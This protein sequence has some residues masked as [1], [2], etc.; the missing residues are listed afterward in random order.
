[1]DCDVDQKAGNEPAGSAAGLADAHEC[2]RPRL[3]AQHAGNSIAQGTSTQLHL[4]DNEAAQAVLPELQVR[5]ALWHY[6][7][8]SML[9]NV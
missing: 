2:H 8:C 1:V 6:P 3:Q 4:A 7:L 5:F 9:L